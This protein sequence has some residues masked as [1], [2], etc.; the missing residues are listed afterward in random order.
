MS[1]A[2]EPFKKII[3]DHLK[4]RAANDQ[5]FAVTLAKPNKSLDDCINYIFA[6]VHKSGCQG[7]AD[8]EVFAMAVHYYDEDDIAKPKAINGKVVV[9]HSIAAPKSKAPKETKP[10]EPI[11]HVATIK[12][13]KPVITNQAA[14]F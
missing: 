12:K 1:K 9:N 3:D 6:E 14:L 13:S 8:E 4:Q 5:L 2:T 10:T 7:F 11:K